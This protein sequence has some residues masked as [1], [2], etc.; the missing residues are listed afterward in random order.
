MNAAMLSQLEDFQAAFGRL[1]E[2]AAQALHEGQS[3]S[4]VRVA[5]AGHGDNIKLAAVRA[6]RVEANIR[7]DRAREALESAGDDPKQ[8]LR[9]LIE[10]GR[11]VRTAVESEYGVRIP[12]S[13]PDT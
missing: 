6:A 2:L 7:S 4:A 10:R 11:I 8:A 1:C 13:N 9:R 5:V 12:F 3:R